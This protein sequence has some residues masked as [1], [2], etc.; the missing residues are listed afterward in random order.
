[1]KDE[2]KLIDLANQWV[3]DLAE[4]HYPEIAMREKVAVSTDRE[5]SENDSR[6]EYI[7]RLIRGRHA[8]R[9]VKE[10]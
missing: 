8:K 2:K 10:N 9:V 3:A 6:F 1:M 7:L 4:T 5:T